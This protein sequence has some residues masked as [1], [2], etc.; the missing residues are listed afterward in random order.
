MTS[1]WARNARRLVIDVV[2]LWRVGESLAFRTF[3]AGF[4]QGEMHGGTAERV[5]EQR[6]DQGIAVFQATA[7][8]GTE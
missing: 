5:V 1:L 8:D 7:N 4:Q 6:G 3:L 2:E